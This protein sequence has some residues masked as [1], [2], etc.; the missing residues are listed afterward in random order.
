MNDVMYHIQMKKGD[1]GRYVFLPGD[2][3]R[4]EKIASYFDDPKLIANNREYKS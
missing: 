1:V 3:G 4:T 2:P